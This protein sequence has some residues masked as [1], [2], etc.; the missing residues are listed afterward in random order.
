MPAAH[1]LK[2]VPAALIT[3]KRRARRKQPLNARNERNARSEQ[4]VTTVARR[5]R[6]AEQAAHSGYDTAIEQ[7]MEMGALLDRRVVS[8]VDA[9]SRRRVE[10][11]PCILCA[12]VFSVS[13]VS[14]VFSVTR[15]RRILSAFSAVSAL[16]LVDVSAPC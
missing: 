7:G 15:V 1:T 4:S 5:G 2:P 3:K 11:L 16:I 10:P 12:S 6:P 13:F 14:S 9:A 8:R